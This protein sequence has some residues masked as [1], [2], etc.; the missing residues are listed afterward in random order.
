M[1]RRPPRST[2]FPYTTLFRSPYMC[3]VLWTPQKLTLD[4]ACGTG[5]NSRTIRLVNSGV[6][7][8]RVSQPKSELHTSSLQS[9]DHV[10]CRLLLTKTEPDF[11]S[12]TSPQPLPY[13]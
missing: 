4:S 12:R 6:Y 9:P 2:L 13:N 11:P 5:G 10:V 3:A 8:I 1:I 7:S